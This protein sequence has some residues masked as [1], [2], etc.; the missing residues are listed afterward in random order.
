MRPTPDDPEREQRFRA[1]YAA[2]YADLLRFV[3]RRTAPDHAEDV[4]AEALLVLWR[5]LEQVP[6]DA[7]EA[8][9]WAF[10]IARNIL[11]NVQR[12]ERRRE[13][14]GIR[15]ADT[16][17]TAVEAEDEL[18]ATRIDLARAWNRLSEVHQ[19]AL[20]LAVFEQLAAAQAA[21]VLGISPV[22]FRLRLSRARRALRLLL[23]HLPEQAG[24]PART[25]RTP[26]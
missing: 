7:G 3:Q 11:L 12:G 22:A 15:I 26:L 4:V 6:D 23:D 25:G 13:A 19:E 24:L 14:L 9:A 17:D 8:R 10:G 21:A 1:L 20:G 2:V 5:R 18:T 16:A